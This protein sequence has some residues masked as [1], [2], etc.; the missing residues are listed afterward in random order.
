MSAVGQFNE[1]V[2]MKN[3]YWGKGVT[4][5]NVPRDEV[6]DRDEAKIQNE[7]DGNWN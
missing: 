5:V 4:A 2:R 7:C 6:K 1:R 3:S